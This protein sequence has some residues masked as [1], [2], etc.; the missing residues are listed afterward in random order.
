MRSIRCL[1]FNNAVCSSCL[2]E[3]YDDVIV[4]LI[5]LVHH[6]PQIYSRAEIT[7]DEIGLSANT[8]CYVVQ[9]LGYLRLIQVD[10]DSDSLMYS[11]AL[12]QC[13]SSNKR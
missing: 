4:I 13:C 8:R 6:N 12:A 1:H 2:R 11:F 9:T 7:F 10:K 5:A 3:V